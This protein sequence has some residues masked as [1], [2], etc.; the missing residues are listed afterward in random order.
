M[1]LGGVEEATELFDP[2]DDLAQ[3]VGVH[4]VDGDECGGG[5]GVP[6]TADEDPQQLGELDLSFRCCTH[7]S[8]GEQRVE[9]LV[10]VTDATNR[11]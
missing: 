4:A 9:R 8:L 6:G 1:C 10:H 11:V 2:D 5:H 7:R 3:R